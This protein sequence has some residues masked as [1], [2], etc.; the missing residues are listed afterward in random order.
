VPRKPREEEAG[1]IH[2][3]FARR[4]EQALL[5]RDRRDHWV[6]LSMLERVVKQSGWRC[7]S[8]CLMPNHM[9]LVIETPRPNLA[10]GMQRLHG[11]YGRWFA[12]GRGKPGHVFGGRYGAVR[13]NDDQQLWAAVAYVAL[14]PI[15][16]G[17]CRTPERWPWSSHG[18]TVGAAETPAWLDLRRLLELLGGGSGGDPRRR[19]ARYV[20]ERQALLAGP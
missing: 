11:D 7:L 5:F 19:Y 3:V 12:R 2:H 9:H 18:A 14:N 1:A 15:A 4:N 20:A 16:A 13:V 10:R 8:Y 17:L 6:Y